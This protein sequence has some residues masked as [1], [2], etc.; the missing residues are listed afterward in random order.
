[1]VPEDER[2]LAFDCIGNLEPNV[3]YYYTAR[4]VDVHEE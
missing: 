1:M 3:K 2:A 4:A